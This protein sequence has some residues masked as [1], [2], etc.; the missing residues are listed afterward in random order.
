MTADRSSSP[1]PKPRPTV[2]AIRAFVPARTTES[3]RREFGVERVLKL[4]GNENTLP[5]SPKVRAAIA[6]AAHGL[7]EY[8]D[9]S[10]TVLVERL[11]RLHGVAQERIVVDNGLFAV[12]S[13]IARAFLDVGDEVILPRPTFGW[14]EVATLTAGGRPVHVA[15]DGSAI[16]LD[17]VAAAVGERTKIVFLCNPNNPTG[18]IFGEAALG[19]FLAAVPG[20]VLVVL[21]EAYVDFVDDPDYPDSRPLLDAH[22]N[23]VVLRTFS[24]LHGLAGLRLG[25]GL[26][27]QRIAAELHK[28]RDP[29]AVNSLA[30]AAGLA[31]L[32]DTAFRTASIAQVVAGRRQ[33]AAALDR[34]GLPSAPSQTN[35]V[36]VDTTIDGDVVTRAA[37]ER[38]ILVRSGRDFGLPSHVRITIG[39]E[40]ENAAVI[41]LLAEVLGEARRIGSRPAV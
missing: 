38:G 4:A 21:D 10:A 22:P 30:Q 23:L 40:A 16:D 18:T 27:D 13:L 33:W 17:R 9:V 35:F 15:S 32:D 37:L 12:V 6:A 19:R 39:N 24:K 8:P 11:A 2:A 20:D 7:G 5:T 26:M 3:V 1:L 41:D 25:Y 31:A 34:L 28:I 14:Y 36:L 29:V